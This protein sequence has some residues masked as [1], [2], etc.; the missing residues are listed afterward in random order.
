MKA[1]SHQPFCQHFE[2]LSVHRDVLQSKCVILALSC[3][4][5]KLRI[6][7]QPR[8]AFSPKRDRVATAPSGLGVEIEADLPS[9]IKGL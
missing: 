1:G 7:T 4:T 3:K 8:V 2:F 6:R 9:I 5:D